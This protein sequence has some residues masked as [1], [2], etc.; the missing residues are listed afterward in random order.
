MCLM[1]VIGGISWIAKIASQP[2]KVIAKTL[3]ADNILYNY[4]W[5]KQTY[6]D[7]RAVEGKIGVATYALLSFV[8][9]AGSRSE[10]DFEDKTEYGRL[11]SVILGLKNQRQDVVAQYNARSK[12]ANR[13]IFKSKELPE[14]IETEFNMGEEK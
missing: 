8:D 7:V 2:A 9:V 3:D 6:H 13:E 4:E 14:T 11:N 12:M 10:W 5:F 1:I